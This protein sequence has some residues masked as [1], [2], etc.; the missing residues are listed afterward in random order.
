[1]VC[2]QRSSAYGRQDFVAIE[3]QAVAVATQGVLPFRRGHQ[4][5]SNAGHAG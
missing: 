1:M 5:T 3:E 2:F 4:V